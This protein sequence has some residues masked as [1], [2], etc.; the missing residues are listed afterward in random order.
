MRVN[1]LIVASLIEGANTCCAQ[2]VSKPTRPRLSPCAGKTPRRSI[3]EG[4]GT[5]AGASRSMA[6][7]LSAMGEAPG[8]SRA[9]GRAR[10]A[11][12][13]ASRNRPG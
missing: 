8:T 2:P 10:L 1:N 6:R 13:K 12:I 11:P 4:D 9:K 5:C 3:A 7:I